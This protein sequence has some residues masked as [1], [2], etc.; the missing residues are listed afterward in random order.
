MTESSFKLGTFNCNGINDSKKRKDT[1]D[2]LRQ[3]K[4]SIYFLQETH[5]QVDSEK[6]IRLGGGIPLG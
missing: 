5:L 2:F 4:Y 3:L 1:F 6:F